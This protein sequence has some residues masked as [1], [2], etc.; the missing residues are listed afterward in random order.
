MRKK[1]KT[2]YTGLIVLLLMSALY[3][4]IYP[5]LGELGSG[6]SE[7]SIETSEVVESAQEDTVSIKESLASEEESASYVED[8]SDQEESNADEQEDVFYNFRYPD[9]L[10]GHFEKHGIEM[11]FSSEEEY[12]EA[13][14]AL[15]D[16]PMCLT[17]T[18]AEDGDMIYFL[19]STNEIAFVS[20]DG[21]LRTYFICSGI[22]YF[23]RQ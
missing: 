17:K 10:T 20:S 23:N 22:D 14:N 15:I 21:Y 9:R 7:S 5:H 1:P 19:E 12:L 16:N 8:S 3:M 11:G 13:A 18:E 6:D 2:Y 4:I